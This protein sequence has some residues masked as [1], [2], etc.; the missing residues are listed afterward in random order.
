MKEAA[1]Q[2]YT[3]EDIAFIIPT[4]DRPDKIRNT[5]QALASQTEKCG[6]V[7]V[8]SSGRNIQQIIDEFSGRLKIDYF[9]CDPPGQ[10][11]QRNLGISKL[12]SSTRLAGF[13][14]DDIILQPDAIEKLIAFWNQ[15]DPDTAGIGFN[16]T[17][18]TGVRQSPLRRLVKGSFRL[19][20][21]P[22]RVFRSGF[23]SSFG[24]VDKSI[25]TDWL[26]GGTTVWRQD[27]VMNSDHREIN[28]SWAINEDVI[29]SYPIGKR[30]PLHICA[31]A[32]AK[33]DHGI[34]APDRQRYYIRGKAWA[35]WHLYFV[36]LHKELSSFFYSVMVFR[37]FLVGSAIVLFYSRDKAFIKYYF[38]MIVGAFRGLLAL[39]RKRDL[40][41]LLE[42][43]NA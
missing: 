25:R 28:V 14:D 19:M 20:I 41:E 35:L 31:E 40:V 38:G 24:N 3:T 26:N 27:I 10:I 4:K 8:V 7:I 23:A 30:H 29:F 16:I 11:R 18:D 43:E 21:P 5:L 1:V 42:K 37:R 2:H 36:S 39:S 13:L 17:E 34:N 33:H 22:G 6:R 32:R 15:Q 9:E 12:D